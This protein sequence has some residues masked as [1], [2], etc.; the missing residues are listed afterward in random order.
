MD[1]IIIFILVVSMIGLLFF[2]GYLYVWVTMGRGSF[3]RGLSKSSLYD[4]IQLLIE[5]KQNQADEYPEILKRTL[6]YFGILIGFLT[7]GIIIALGKI[8]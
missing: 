8:I 5:A 7:L 6:I 2:L 1:V 4:V 3:W